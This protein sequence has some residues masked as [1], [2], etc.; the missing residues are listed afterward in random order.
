VADPVRTCVGCRRRAPQ[1]ELIRL[2]RTPEGTLAVGRRLPG[3]G[4]WL[5]AG[6]TACLE[7]AARRNALTRALR[8]PVTADAVS[9]LAEGLDAG[10]VG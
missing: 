1:R 10:P 6:S 9:A 4:A 8:A 2:V 7:R 5:C 3:R